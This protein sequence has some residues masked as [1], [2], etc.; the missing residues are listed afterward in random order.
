M[1]ETN[2]E[3]CKISDDFAG[4]KYNVNDILNKTIA[5]TNYKRE[6]S[7]KHS[8]TSYYKIQ[9]ITIGPDGSKHLGFLTCGA[10]QVVKVLDQNP[11]I[12]LYRTFVQVG[13]S[14]YFK[15]N[16]ASTEET[17]D[18]LTQNLNIDFTKLQ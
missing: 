3:I 16:M 15:E 4:I 10:Q 8:G 11:P 2:T 17:I 7:V 5:I 6:I 12:P 13:R 14:V 9:F 18:K 1:N